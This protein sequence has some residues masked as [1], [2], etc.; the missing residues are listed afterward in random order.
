MTQTSEIKK[1]LETH[2]RGLTSMDAFNLF[3]A[4]RLSAIVYQLRNVHGMNIITED[5]IVK[6]RYGRPVTVCVYKL[7]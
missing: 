6:N 4:T 1:Y 3:G 7:A 5:K 2:K